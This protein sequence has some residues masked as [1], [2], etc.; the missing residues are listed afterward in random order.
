MDTMTR[1]SP[2]LLRGI[3]YQLA[4]IKILRGEKE[5]PVVVGVFKRG[6]RE[7]T[8]YVLVD[9]LEDEDPR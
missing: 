8:V 7:A 4:D 1:P 6:D 5:D 2:R 3:G 9:R